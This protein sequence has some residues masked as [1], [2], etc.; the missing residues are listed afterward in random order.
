MQQHLDAVLLDDDA[1]STGR[2]ARV[3]HESYWAEAR[4]VMDEL[5]ETRPR[6]RPLRP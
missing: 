6:R 4:E 3:H 1:R 2:G 5:I